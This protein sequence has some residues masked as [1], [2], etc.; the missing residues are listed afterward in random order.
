[1]N[2]YSIL[3]EK[4]KEKTDYSKVIDIYT[5]TQGTSAILYTFSSIGFFIGRIFNL[6]I[7]VSMYLARMLNLIFSLF[8]GYFSLK[9]IPFGK[10]VLMIY[11]FTPMYFQQGASIS[12]DCII[13]A[14]IIFFI[15]YVMAL[16]FREKNINLRERILFYILVVII[17]ISKYI[18][19]PL[20]GLILLLIQNKSVNKNNKIKMIAIGI[21]LAC[22]VSVSWYIFSGRYIEERDYISQMSVNSGEQ[23]KNII[24]NP[25]T[26][27]KVLFNSIKEDSEAYIFTFIGSVLG[28]L[29]IEINYLII[30][31]FLFLLIVTPFLEKSD[32]EFK[33]IAR[34][35][36]ALIFIVISILIIIG[37]YIGWSPVGWYKAIG[38]QGRYFIPCAILLLLC[39]TSKT[40]YIEF[41]NIDIKLLLTVFTLNILT[42]IQVIENFI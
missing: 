42:I 41:K 21:S 34:I 35:W 38:I 5:P 24:N 19:I 16:I 17:A 12:S 40:K 23:I 2:K 7:I 9:L 3:A 18:Y 31:I 15:A 25:T 1:M 28:W 6:N 32:K 37:L 14:V 33:V 8:L 30:A 22:I 11:M 36:Y 26:I 20:V 4:I 29:N 13:N 27:F 39:L 10:K